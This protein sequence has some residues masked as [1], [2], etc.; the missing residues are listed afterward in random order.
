MPT[1]TNVDLPRIYGG[2]HLLPS[3][4]AS[5]ASSQRELCTSRAA[6]NAYH[7]GVSTLWLLGFHDDLLVAQLEL[8]T[9][10]LNLLNTVH[11]KEGWIRDSSTFLSVIVQRRSGYLAKNH[12]LSIPNFADPSCSSA[13]FHLILATTPQTRAVPQPRPDFYDRRNTLEGHNLAMLEVH[14]PDRRA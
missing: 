1:D 6:S 14:G 5:R 13:V 10:G 4:T 3:H 9:A 7:A 11:A 2:T 8:L 12:Q